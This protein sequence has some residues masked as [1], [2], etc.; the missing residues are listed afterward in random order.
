LKQNDLKKITGIISL[1]SLAACNS[2]SAP[3]TNDVTDNVLAVEDAI[4][5]TITGTAATGRPSSGVVFAVGI[6][7][8]EVNTSI[9]AD[10]NYEINVALLTP[11]FILRSESNDGSPTQYSYADKANT[12]A[13]ITQFTSLALFLTNDKKE[14][15]S[16]AT[17]TEWASSYTA[18]S[19]DK[20]KENIGIINNNFKSL[21]QNQNLPENYDFFSEPFSADH[22]SIDSILDSVSIVFNNETNEYLVTVDGATL[23]F[24]EGY[25]WKRSVDGSGAVNGFPQD[26]SLPEDEVVFKSPPSVFDALAVVTSNFASDGVLQGTTTPNIETETKR[27]YSFYESGFFNGATVEY[28]VTI[29]YIKI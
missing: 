25:L 2:S 15:A 4:S 23:E 28:S 16:V 6:R 22:T 14:L 1:L 26:F 27:Q 10:G 20:L 21:L 9:N 11:P 12:V 13:N 19:N 7:G 5:S 3:S 24:R 18:L 29:N 17:S 8:T